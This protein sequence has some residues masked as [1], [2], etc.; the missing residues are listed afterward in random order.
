MLQLA[1][2]VKVETSIEPLMSSTRQFKF[3]FSGYESHLDDYPDLDVLSATEGMLA[4]L[5]KW[6][7]NLVKRILGLSENRKEAAKDTEKTTSQLLKNVPS[8]ADWEKKYDKKY[9]YLY[10]Y[11]DIKELV[12]YLSEYDKTLTRFI[13][14]VQK[15]DAS[16]YQKHP[17][18]TIPKLLETAFKP[19]LTKEDIETCNDIMSTLLKTTIKKDHFTAVIAAAEKVKTKVTLTSN[20]DGTVTSVFVDMKDFEQEENVSFADMGYPKNIKELYS[21][22]QSKLFDFVNMY[23]AAAETNQ[24]S[25]KSLINKAKNLKQTSTDKEHQ[26]FYSK[27]GAFCRIILGQS[28]MVLKLYDISIR[29]HK[30]INKI[31][32]MTQSSHTSE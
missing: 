7:V 10:K 12:A 2:Y 30:L 23:K 5:W 29:R 21:N 1:N 8:D 17:D 27:V 15:Y 14:D 13:E 28:V 16:E 6:I 18:K 20:E 25:M 4:D 31:L 22:T 24:E 11:S 3:S 19:D 32:L 9:K 26:K